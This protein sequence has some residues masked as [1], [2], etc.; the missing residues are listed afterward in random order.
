MK[1]K[2]A[3]KTD[4]IQGSK[5]LKNHY[6]LQH[7]LWESQISCSLIHTSA[8]EFSRLVNYCATSKKTPHTV[9]WKGKYTDEEPQFSQ[10][11]FSF[12]GIRSLLNSG[13]Q[14]K[15]NWDNSFQG[16]QVKITL[17]LKTRTSCTTQWFFRPLVLPPTKEQTWQECTKHPFGPSNI[18]YGLMAVLPSSILH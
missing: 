9:T 16:K 5:K 1:K 13:T 7:C 6:F 2:K 11:D 17:G 12:I 4:Q 18:W 10:E 15:E 3:N 14:L 8:V